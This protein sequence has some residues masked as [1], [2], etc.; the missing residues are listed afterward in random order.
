M[1]LFDDFVELEGFMLSNNNYVLYY[2]NPLTPYMSV[3]I[4]LSN[5]DTQ[6]TI[7]NK[8]TKEIINKEVYE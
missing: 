7:R 2:I 3:T 5:G 8:Y 4:P 6:V 1:I